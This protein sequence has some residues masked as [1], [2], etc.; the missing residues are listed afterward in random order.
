MNVKALV[1]PSLVRYLGKHSEAFLE[2]HDKFGDLNFES[3][4]F[5]MVIMFSIQ[6]SNIAS[7][8]HMAKLLSWHP[9]VLWFDPD[10]SLTPFAFLRHRCGK[11]ILFS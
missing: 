9:K 2:V 10:L 11:Q 5:H 8:P 4:L 3:N 6:K 7:R 1:N